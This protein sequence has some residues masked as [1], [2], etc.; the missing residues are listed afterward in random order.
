MDELSDDPMTQNL[1]WQMR[2]EEEG[3]RVKDQGRRGKGNHRSIGDKL[4]GYTGEKL[5]DRRLSR[6]SRSTQTTGQRQLAGSASRGTLKAMS[7]SH[8]LCQ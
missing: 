5:C 4:K 6:G 7:G 2:E 8:T 3:A 1:L